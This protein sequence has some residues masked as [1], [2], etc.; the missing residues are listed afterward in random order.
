MPHHPSHASHA[1]LWR[2]L[3]LVTVLLLLQAG[4]PQSQAWLRLD[5]AALAQGQWWRL[6]SA[7]L[8]HL[9]WAHALLN[10]V[11]VLLCWALAPRLFD[12]AL[13]WRLA[14][15]AL[16]TSLCLWAFTP[17]VLPYVGL[18]G[19]LYGLFVLGLVPQLRG[20]RDPIAALALGLVIGWMLWQW[21][22]GAPAAEEALLGGRVVSE[23]HL[24]G[25]GLALLWLLLKALARRLG[26][27]A[28]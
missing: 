7:H 8:V 18:S 5:A 17:Q 16:G 9:G 19:V 11:G 3:L 20:A 2:A 25:A 14:G 22:A 24:F 12:A 1:P 10:A 28:G 6:F 27:P 4:P 26:H 23:A 21:A 15:L 13:P